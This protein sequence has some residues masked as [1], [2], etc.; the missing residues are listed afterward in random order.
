[1]KNDEQNQDQN[2]TGPEPT[3]ESKPT[4]E[5]PAA[6]DQGDGATSEPAEAEQKQEE[7]VGVEG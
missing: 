7:P 5:A 3:E 4:G 2:S 6:S 1:V